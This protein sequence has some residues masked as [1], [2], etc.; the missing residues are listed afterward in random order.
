MSVWQGV[1]QCG[2][3]FVVLRMQL[4]T[5]RFAALVPLKKVHAR[6]DADAAKRKEVNKVASI[7]I[8]FFAAAEPPL[9][10]RQRALIQTDNRI[11][12]QSDAWWEPPTIDEAN[13][14]AL[15]DGAEFAR[16]VFDACASGEIGERAF[17]DK[18]RANRQR[19]RYRV[20]PIK[21]E[22]IFVSQWIEF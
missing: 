15:E 3:H 17:M 18:S 8:N 6:I 21:G 19:D 7:R 22:K 11:N 20:G 14:A 13:L 5:C 16:A 2:A 9:Q 1:V 10:I 4:R 12:E